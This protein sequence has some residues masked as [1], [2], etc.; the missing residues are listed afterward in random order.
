YKG[1]PLVRDT[2]RPVL[3]MTPDQAANLS[4]SY[5]PVDAGANTEPGM[6]GI[7]MHSCLR[8]IGT[9]VR[10]K[11]PEQSQTRVTYLASP[12]NSMTAGPGFAAIWHVRSA[13][14]G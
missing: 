5:D 6:I 10:L 8:R 12:D 2:W 1:P 11:T 7:Y 3:L 9:G 14:V 4:A 13:P